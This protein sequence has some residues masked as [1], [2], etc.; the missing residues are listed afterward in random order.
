MHASIGSFETPASLSYY[1]AIPIFTHTCT[2]QTIGR[3]FAL[4]IGLGD[5]GMDINSIISNYNASVT[6]AASELL[7]KERRRKQALGHKRCSQHLI[8]GEI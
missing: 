2:F 3:K 4:L 7:G 1:N 6:D 5:E 8:R